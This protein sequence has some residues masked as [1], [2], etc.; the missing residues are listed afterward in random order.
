MNNTRIQENTVLPEKLSQRKYQPMFADQGW[1]LQ[2]RLMLLGE[3]LLKDK[4]EE[5]RIDL[6]KQRY[7]DYLFVCIA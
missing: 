5:M 2:N 4:A 3:S 7:M 6:S 1:Y